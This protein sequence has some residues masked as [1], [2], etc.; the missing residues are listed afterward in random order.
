MRKSDN[1]ALRHYDEYVASALRT[2]GG[3]LSIGRDGFILYYAG[4][5]RLE[6]HAALGL[7][8][9]TSLGRGQPGRLPTSSFSTVIGNPYGQKIETAGKAGSYPIPVPPRRESSAMLLR[10]QVAIERCIC[11][12]EASD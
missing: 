11:G 7:A 10:Y 9:P 8:R 12:R 3:H 2:E 1:P 4:G 6:H 5:A